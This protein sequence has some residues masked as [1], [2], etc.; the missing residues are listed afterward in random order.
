MIEVNAGQYLNFTDYVSFAGSLEVH[1][2]HITNDT[3]NVT[4][5]YYRGSTSNFT[6]IQIITISNT[7]YATPATPFASR[8]RNQ[9]GCTQITSTYG[10]TSLII[11]YYQQCSSSFEGGS[12]ITGAGDGNPIVGDRR[13]RRQQHHK[14]INHWTHR[15]YWRLRYPHPSPCHHRRCHSWPHQQATLCP[16]CQRSC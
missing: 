4:V 11:G 15:R 13:R 5:A 1:V 6:N 8:K 7:S 9:D 14:T 2:N 12:T 3:Q 16:C 10:L